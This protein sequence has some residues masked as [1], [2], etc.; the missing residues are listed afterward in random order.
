MAGSYR[1]VTN[2]DATF[3]GFGL[4]ENRK[5]CCEAIEEMWLMI[6]W[7][8]GGDKRKIHEAWLEGYFKKECPPENIDLATYERFWDE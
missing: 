1:H 3:H 6:D 2:V 5:D 7:L 4:V 8:T